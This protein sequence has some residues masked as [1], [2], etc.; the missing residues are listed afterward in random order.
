MNAINFAGLIN[1]LGYA[2][3]IALYAMLLA[4]VLRHPNQV[5]SASDLS[6]TGKQSGPSVN[7]LMLATAILGL[8]WNVGALATYGMRG[9][10]FANTSPT[11][12]AISLTALG[13]LP[14]VVVQSVLLNRLG[15]TNGKISRAISP[16]R[17]TH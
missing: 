15:Q 1:L 16:S 8:L 7:G 13:F 5:A 12:S 2:M 3:G 17:P 9:F 10:G 14:A 6:R 4:I 11:L